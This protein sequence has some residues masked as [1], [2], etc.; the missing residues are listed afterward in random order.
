MAKPRLRPIEADYIPQPQPPKRYIRKCGHYNDQTLDLLG[1]DN[2]I[3]SYC[4]G[5]LIER[6]GLTPIANHK[7]VDGKLVKI[8]EE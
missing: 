1:E 2:I 4:L 3:R 7:I 8:W 6:V 5:C